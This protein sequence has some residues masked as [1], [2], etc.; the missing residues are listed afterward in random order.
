MPQCDVIAMKDLSS[1]MQHPSI[2]L[3]L[4]RNQKDPNAVFFF[5]KSMAASCKNEIIVA[6]R[7][8]LEVFVWA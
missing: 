3:M 4:P 6:C 5:A 8:R 2:A 1:L 7:R